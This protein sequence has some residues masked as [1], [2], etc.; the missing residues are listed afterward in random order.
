MC[1]L[2]WLYK[3]CKFEVHWSIFYQHDIINMINMSYCGKSHWN[4]VYVKSRLLT[5]FKFT[6]ERLDWFC[7]ECTFIGSRYMTQGPGIECLGFIHRYMYFDNIDFGLE[8]Y[9][10]RYSHGERFFGLG[11]TIFFGRGGGNEF[12]KVPRQYFCY[13][14]FDDQIFYVPP[15]E[16]Q[17]W[18][19]M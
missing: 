18:R 14:L 1:D 6:R 9:K 19:N 15:P 13:S 12:P 8:T 2:Y 3:L 7:S 11:A 16:L 10:S 17:C 4:G 5:K